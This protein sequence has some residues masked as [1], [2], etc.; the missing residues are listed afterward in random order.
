LKVVISVT[1]PS[2]LICHFERSRSV[3]DGEVEKPAFLFPTAIYI[4]SRLEWPIQAI[5]WLEWG[6]C[7]PVSLR[8]AKQ[9][10]NM[11]R[12]DNISQHDEPAAKPNPFQNLQKQITVSGIAEDR[13]Q[14]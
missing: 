9:E 1:P 3:S 4:G 2:K 11:L 7:R 8:F 12:H 13:M 14:R 5:L 10:M 6:I